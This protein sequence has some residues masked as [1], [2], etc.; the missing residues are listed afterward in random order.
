MR[1]RPPSRSAAALPVLPGNVGILK[2]GARR[3]DFRDPYH[4]AVSA[5]WP[6]FGLSALA[7]W[8]AINLLF[9]SLYSLSAG[10]ISNAA[11][12]SFSDAF[13]FSVET[14]ATVG[15]GVMAPTTPYTH[16]VSATE[17]VTGMAFTAIATGLLFV[18]FS[19]PKAKISYAEQAVVTAFNDHH[20]LMIRLANG[21]MTVMTN[22]NARLFALIGEHTGQGKYFR[23]IFNLPLVQ[24]Q[25]PLFVMP[26]TLMHVI[27]EASPLHGYGPERI[28]EA[29][30]RLFLAVDAR[31]QAIDTTVYDM[32]LYM[33][34]EIR[35]G[36]R[37]AESVTLDDE[38]HITADLSRLSIL[39]PDDVVDPEWALWLH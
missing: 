37:Y 12:H 29:D 35:F 21:R 26:W 28:V 25:I 33:P 16:I 10:G 6:M 14:L 8:A 23:R 32:K 4:L 2:K 7:V 17:I 15:Y 5:S 22:A 36:M 34:T 39:E 13:F 30:I 18:R 11:P 19:R 20:T 27:D 38:G 1:V 9:A 24:P 3:Y 31:D